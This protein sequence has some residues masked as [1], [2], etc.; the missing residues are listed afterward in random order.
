MAGSLAELKTKVTDVD[1]WGIRKL[2]PNATGASAQEWYFNMENATS[3]PRL[4]NHSPRS[5]LRRISDDG[6]WYVDGIAKYMRDGEEKEGKGEVRLE[7]WSESGNKKWLNTEVTVYG[8]YIEDLPEKFAQSKTAFQLYSGGGHHSKD[9]K[10]EAGGYKI[11]L[12]KDGRVAVRKEPQHPFYCEDRGTNKITDKTVKGRWIGLKQVRYNIKE[13]NKV[14]VANEIWIDEESD[15]NGK[16]VPRN[17]WRRV[18][19]VKDSGGWGLS[20][21]MSDQERKKYIEERWKDDCPLQ[22]SNVVDRQHRK[23]E[24]IINMPGGT[25]DGNLAALRC[26][27]LKLKFKYFSVREI[28]PPT[29]P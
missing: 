29:S 25:D 11:R 9:R 24:D 27:G 14:C 5:N 22:D 28:E 4:K 18:A 19:D 20:K 21:D 23:I 13:D 7:A 3:D 15:D 6:S 12:F 8:F 2:Y 10:C 16:L 1:Q 17:G 26:D